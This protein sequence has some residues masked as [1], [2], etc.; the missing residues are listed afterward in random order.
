MT[1]GRVMAD[2]AEVV[3]LWLVSSFP[4][5]VVTD[6][7]SST[8]AGAPADVVELFGRAEEGLVGL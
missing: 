8:E 1:E 3:S 2:V 7:G 4:A 6:E 5:G